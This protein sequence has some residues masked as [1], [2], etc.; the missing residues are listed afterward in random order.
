MNTKPQIILLFGF[1]FVRESIS[2]LSI[3]GNNKETFRPMK[4]FS[5]AV[6]V[7]QSQ[8]DSDRSSGSEKLE[9]NDTNLIGFVWF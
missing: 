3:R 2:K 5:L 7:A 6:F 4:K 1:L 8:Q 9:K